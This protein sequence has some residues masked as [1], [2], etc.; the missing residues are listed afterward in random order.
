MCQ[1]EARAAALRTNANQ[2][3]HITLAAA[4]TAERFYLAM[5]FAV[6]EVLARNRER[7][8]KLCGIVFSN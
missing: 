6:I 1:L 2:Y 4:E 7:N 5:G 3:T 8:V